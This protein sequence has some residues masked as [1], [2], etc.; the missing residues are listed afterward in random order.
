MGVNIFLPALNLGGGFVHYI[1][2]FIVIIT[3][4]IFFHELGHFAVARFFGVRVETFSIGFGPAIVSWMD[5]KGTRWKISWLPLGGYVKFL[6]DADAASTPDQEAAANMSAEERAVALQF[7]PVHQRAAVAAAG[8]IANFI[9]AIVVLTIFFWAF[10]AMTAPAVI[11]SVARNSP[12]QAAG[13]RAGDRIVD[14]DGRHI[15]TFDDMVAVVAMR[16]GEPLTVT[17]QRANATTALHVTPRLTVVKD[18]LGNTEKVGQLGIYSLHP[19]PVHY[20]LTGALS[21]ACHTTWQIV[22]STLDMLRLRLSANSVAVS[23]IHGPLGIGKF[24]AEVAQVS[25]LSLAKLAAFI[26]ISVGLINLFPIP[27][28]DGGHL[29]YYGIEAVLGR[30]LGARAQDVGFRLGLAFILGLA[31]LSTWN[32]LVWLNPF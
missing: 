26:S 20:G 5:R 18:Q 15:E 28:L 10:G 9:L 7:R 30:P 12:A 6:G 17:V 22:Q 24:A 23:Q 8:P 4:V 1:L 14:I 27:L 31:L 3:P 11:G 13:F 16:A 2:P 19:H 25:V 29:L 32:D 21:E